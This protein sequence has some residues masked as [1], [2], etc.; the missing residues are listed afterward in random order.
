MRALDAMGAELLQVLLLRRVSSIV[1]V[2]NVHQLQLRIRLLL[3]PAHD[4][5]HRAFV[6][7]CAHQP[8]RFL[9]TDVQQIRQRIVTSHR[10]HEVMLQTLGNQDSGDRHG[11][12]TVSHES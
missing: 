9:K 11:G 2:A 12:I 3:R 8:P 1:P 5:R 7:V 6:G 4:A 10:R